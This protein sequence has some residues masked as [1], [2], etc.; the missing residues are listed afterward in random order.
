MLPL[1]VCDAVV[2][3]RIS[4]GAPLRRFVGFHSLGG[5]FVDGPMIIIVVAV[6]AAALVGFMLRLAGK[7]GNEDVTNEVAISDIGHSC[8]VYS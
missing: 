3:L 1:A 5:A 4:V 7:V 8:R 6:I 2:A